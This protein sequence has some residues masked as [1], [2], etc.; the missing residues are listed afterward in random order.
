MTTSAPRAL[1]ALLSVSK[2]ACCRHLSAVDNKLVKML[3]TAVPES[4]PTHGWREAIV[5][6][7]QPAWEHPS[8]VRECQDGVTMVAGLCTPPLG[9]A[10]T[11]RSGQMTAT[12]VGS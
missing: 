6:A 1:F 7:L 4:D 5:L 3:T 11:S 2:L 9:A 12:V 10:F 8:G